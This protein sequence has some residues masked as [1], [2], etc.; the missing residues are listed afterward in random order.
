MRSFRNRLLAAAAAVA[1]TGAAA[2]QDG[3]G[4]PRDPSQ[5]YSAP[6]PPTRGGSVAVPLPPSG[7]IGNPSGPSSPDA[8]LPSDTPAAGQPDDFANP[9]DGAVD[10]SQPAILDTSRENAPS[11][12]PYGVLPTELSRRQLEEQNHDMKPTTVEVED[13]G[14]GDPSEKGTIDEAHGGLGGDLWGESDYP[15]IAE[16]LEEMPVAT[17]S[18]AMNGLVRRVLLTGAKPKAALLDDLADVL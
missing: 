15:T 9:S 10:P 3:S 13:L 18:P 11:D 16:L 4:I 1:L 7:T 5:D 14:E 12:L 8:F 17:A 6:S 2:A